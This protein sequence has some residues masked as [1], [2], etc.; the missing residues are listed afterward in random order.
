MKL[1]FLDEK[2]KSQTTEIMSKLACD[3]QLS[4]KP[5]GGYV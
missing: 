5:E 3:A 2:Y 4:G 1:L